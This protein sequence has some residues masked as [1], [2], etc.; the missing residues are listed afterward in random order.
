MRNFVNL[1]IL[2]ASFMLYVLPT[3]AVSEY[4][5]ESQADELNKLGLYAGISQENFE[6]ALDRE[7]NRIEGAVMIVRLLGV[8]LENEDEE[9]PKVQDA[10]VIVEEK[11]TDGVVIPDW[12]VR[13]IAY[14]VENGYIKGY[15]DGT[16]KP[17]GD[18][19][20]RA[21]CAM[22][23][24]NL[25]YDFKYEEAGAV[26]ADAAAIYD[27]DERELFSANKLITRD[28]LI[29]ITFNAL[30]AYYAHENCNILRSL[31][32]KEA[33]NIGNLVGGIPDNLTGNGDFE[34]VEVSSD[35]IDVKFRRL[36][37]Y[38]YEKSNGDI[39]VIPKTGNYTNP[40][41]TKI[42][43]I[44][45]LKKFSLSYKNF[46]EE[47][48]VYTDW[49]FETNSLI[50]I[51]IGEAYGSINHYFKTAEIIGKDDEILKLIIN[52]VSYGMQTCD[53][54]EWL[55]LIEI[56]KNMLFESPRIMIHYPIQNSYYIEPK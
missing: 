39:T 13:H 1:S 29:G 30:D 32:E 21:Y 50:A 12:A 15:P 52:R 28:T 25:G 23:V 43:S 3:Q 56:N 7:V 49:Y 51:G 18:L 42:H 20:G 38:G 36:R 17:Y 6:P 54:A 48:S 45:D 27:D 14:G 8:T 53:S 2:V 9:L 41:I 10:R 34:R 19:V 11:F 55:F 47:S 46:E 16:F 31:I 22:I 4:W 26:F 33:I 37:A 35:I 44:N 40:T 24:S 5:Y